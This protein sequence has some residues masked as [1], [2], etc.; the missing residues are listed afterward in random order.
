MVMAAMI[1]A[2]E[3][4]CMD[5]CLLKCLLLLKPVEECKDACNRKC[6]KPPNV[7][8]HQSETKIR[9]MGNIKE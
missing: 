5:I 3:R 4:R 9:G 6:H 2:D 1:T 8:Y 7:P